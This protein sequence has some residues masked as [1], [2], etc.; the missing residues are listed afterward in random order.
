MALNDADELLL[1]SLRR[2]SVPVPAAL[3]ALNGIEPE[4]LIA[5]VV[6]SVRLIL[7]AQ[8]SPVP[9]LADRL[10]VN[11]SQRHKVRMALCH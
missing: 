9:A 6:S 7:G 4:T 11:I 10:P 2:S 5:I 3:V 1:L 8:G